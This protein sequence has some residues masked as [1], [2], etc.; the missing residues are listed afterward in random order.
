MNIH[1]DEKI[2]KKLTDPV[3]SLVISYGNLA[4]KCSKTACFQ[5]GN[6]LGS[7]ISNE[8]EASLW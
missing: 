7:L 6:V 8:A 5:Q 2:S 1:S 4:D 3:G